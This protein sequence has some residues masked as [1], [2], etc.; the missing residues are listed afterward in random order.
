[1]NIHTLYSRTKSLLLHI[2]ITFFWQLKIACGCP[3]YKLA[4]RILQNEEQTC[5]QRKYE[6]LKNRDK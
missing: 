5:T 4:Q 3:I 2:Y 6:D 1:M